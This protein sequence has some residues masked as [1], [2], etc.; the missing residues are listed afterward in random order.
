M[1]SSI[2]SL[3]YKGY[4]STTYIKHKKVRGSGGLF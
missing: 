1:I 4:N 2:T 3:S